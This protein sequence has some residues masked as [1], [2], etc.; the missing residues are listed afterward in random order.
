MKRETMLDRSLI[1]SSVIVQRSR[2]VFR[3]IEEMKRQ[4]L[5]RSIIQEQY[6]N[7]L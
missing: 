5:S 3:D 7:A 2:K 6:F 4:S 1:I